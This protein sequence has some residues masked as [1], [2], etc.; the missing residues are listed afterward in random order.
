VPETD[1]GGGFPGSSFKYTPL[2]HVRVL[3]IRFVQGLFAGA[4]PGSYHWDPDEEKTEIIVTNESRIDPETLMRRPAISFT[5]G[6]IQFYSMGIDDMH[7]YDF[8][9]DKKTKDV[10]VPGTMNVNVISR[11]SIESEDLAWVVT[12]HIWLLRDLLLKAGFYDVGRAPQIGAPS[13]AGSLIAG[14]QGE[15]FTVTAITV[16]FQ[17]SRTSSFTPLGKRIAEGI[18]QELSLSTTTARSLGPPRVSHELPVSVV[19]C[20]PEP[21]A[22]NASDVQGATPDPAG[23]RQVF[24]PKQ[25]HPLNPAKTVHVRTVRPNAAGS[26]VRANVVLVPITRPCVE[27]SEGT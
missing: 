20:A 19:E 11:V 9:L 18:R 24:L 14:D 22:P 12:E 17:F 4:P 23:T 8:A 13:P 16:P 5:R 2:R 6:P 3:F 1:P 10:L 21:F 27:E 7:Q 15:E 25:P 26:R